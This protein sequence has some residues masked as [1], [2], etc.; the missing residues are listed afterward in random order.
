MAAFE[1]SFSGHYNPQRIDAV[2]FGAWHDPFVFC[3]VCALATVSFPIPGG[4]RDFLSVF[5]LH[6][7]RWATSETAFTAL[8]LRPT[9]VQATFTFLIFV[10]SSTAAP[11]TSHVH[12]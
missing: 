1:I 9:V 8:N 7:L 6:F 5:I 3:L 12:C 10:S 2:V 4:R 11:V